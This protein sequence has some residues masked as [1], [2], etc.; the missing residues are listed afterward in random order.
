MENIYRFKCEK[1]IGATEHFYKPSCVVNQ[2][3]ENK[4]NEI[5]GLLSYLKKPKTGKNKRGNLLLD[6]PNRNTFKEIYTFVCNNKMLSDNTEYQSKMNFVYN[7]SLNLLKHR[8]ALAHYLK[9]I[10]KEIIET[11]LGGRKCL[12]LNDALDYIFHFEPEKPFEVF[13]DIKIAIYNYL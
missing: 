9:P 7:L 13:D 6:N 1:I 4:L 11:S 12:E 8:N 3:W 10:S 2:E 5:P